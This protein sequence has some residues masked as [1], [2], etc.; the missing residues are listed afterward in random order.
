MYYE[1]KL[2]NGV[3]MYRTEPNGNWQQCSIEKMGERILEMK[4]TLAN[5]QTSELSVLLSTLRDVTN[6]AD[7]N[8]CRHEETHRGGFLWEIC[9]TCGAKWADDE[10]G[11]LPFVEPPAIIKA[12]ELLNKYDM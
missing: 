5:L 9:N 11:K 1:E 8:I 2:I 6:L 4:I 7:N 12:Y 10:G 3:L